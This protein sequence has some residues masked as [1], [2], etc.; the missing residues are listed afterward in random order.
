MLKPLLPSIPQKEILIE[1][2]CYQVY[3][4]V[5]TDILPKGSKRIFFCLNG[6]AKAN[7]IKTFRKI[8]DLKERD[9]AIHLYVED[10]LTEFHDYIEQHYVGDRFVK[11]DSTPKP[12]VQNTS[13]R[14]QGY[15]VICYTYK[16]S[17]ENIVKNAA[18]ARTTRLVGRAEKVTKADID[19]RIA[20]AEK[21]QQEAL[22]IFKTYMEAKRKALREQVEKEIQERDALC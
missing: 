14:G 20:K 21:H 18:V 10:I 6:K 11:I 15:V 16:R 1:G 3:D 13:A 8:T 19:E 12:T 9:K 7:H 2:R 4:Q 17:P 5:R 22:E